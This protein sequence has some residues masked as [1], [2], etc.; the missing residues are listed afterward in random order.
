MDEEPVQDEADAE[1]TQ[2]ETDGPVEES[3]GTAAECECAQHEHGE[4]PMEVDP[5]AAMFENLLS[6][7]TERWKANKD[8]SKKVTWDGFDE[9]DIFTTLC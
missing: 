7:C 6:H 3:S 5:L 8:D 4:Y 1:D 9:V 2:L